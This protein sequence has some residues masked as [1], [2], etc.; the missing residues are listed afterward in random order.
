MIVPPTVTP[1]SGLRWFGEPMTK[2]PGDLEA[3]CDRMPTFTRVPFGANATRDVIVRDPSDLFTE[4]LPVGVV[5]K[6]YVLLQHRDVLRAALDAFAAC[7]IPVA[8]TTSDVLIS[9]SG[10]RMAARVRLPGAQAFDPG[11]G[12][13]ID[14]TFECFNS[15]DGTVPLFALLGWFRLVC[16]NGLVLGT[17][18]ARIWKK[19][20]PALDTREFVMLLQDGVVAAGLDRAGLRAWQSVPVGDRVLV[21]WIDGPVA[22]AWGALAAGRVYCIARTGYDATPLCRFEKVRPHER[23]F[24]DPA[25]RVPGAPERSRTIFDVV[26]ALSW[27]ASSRNDFQQRIDWR[28]QIPAL[29]RGLAGASA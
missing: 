29:A 12:E 10:S 9:A 26:Q 21:P 15:V 4:A 19:H 3:A 25:V 11:D 23:E 16:S 1:R 8:A 13:E 28:A 22:A 6:R 27:V 20:T 18:A 14:L 24:G 2:V 17:A 5:S 7:G